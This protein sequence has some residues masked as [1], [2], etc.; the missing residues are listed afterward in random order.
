MPV[1]KGS[2]ARA[3]SASSKKP[4]LVTKAVKKLPHILTDIKIEEILSVPRDWTRESNNNEDIH[5]LKK[6]IQDYGLIEPVI[7]RRIS[8]NQFQLLSGYQ[9]LR[10]VSE[11]GME[12]ISSRVIDDLSEDKAKELFKD[13]HRRAGED[14][15]N[16]Q[17]AKF[18][19]AS[20]MPKE[21]PIHLL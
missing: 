5:E 13:L 1:G 16:I 21:M 11:L 15:V 4:S 6:S 2:I 20:S 18:I 9:R 3:T 12:F 17:E 10:A 8:N 14:K 7:L 19:V